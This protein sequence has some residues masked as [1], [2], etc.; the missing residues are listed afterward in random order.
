MLKEIDHSAILQEPANQLIEVF[1]LFTFFGMV[2]LFVYFVLKGVD[3]D[4]KKV[5]AILGSIIS[6]L[7][8]A[9]SIFTVINFYQKPNLEKLDYANNKIVELANEKYGVE[10]LES[11]VSNDSPGTVQNIIETPIKANNPDGD[12]IQVFIEVTEDNKDILIFSNGKE[13]P[14]KNE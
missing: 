2:P 9:A 10:I 12:R 4:I 13:L 11:T 5:P 7:I 6:V 14:K 3:G 1:S 8:A